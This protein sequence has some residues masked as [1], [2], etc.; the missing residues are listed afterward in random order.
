MKNLNTYIT[1]KFKISKNIKFTLSKKEVNDKIF[2]VISSFK[3]NHGLNPNSWLMYKVN[4]EK[5]ITNDIDDTWYIEVEI[6]SFVVRFN[7]LNL[8]E[9]VNKLEEE[10]GN[11]VEKIK[12]DKSYDKEYIKIYFYSPE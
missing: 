11:S 3:E 6:D 2:S 5:Y 9:L 12:R 1:E 4:S 10:L 8:D 7:H